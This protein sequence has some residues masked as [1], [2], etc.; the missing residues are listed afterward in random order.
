MTV[1]GCNKYY[2]STSRRSAWTHFQE[3]LRQLHVY[4]SLSLFVQTVTLSFITV[5]L[6]AHHLTVKIIDGTHRHMSRKF[7][8]HFDLTVTTRLGHLIP[9]A[10][11]ASHIFPPAN[12][13]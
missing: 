2:R 3:R 9:E 11:T 6:C 13:D 1:E 4:C 12:K 5:Y 8:S 7:V 10:T